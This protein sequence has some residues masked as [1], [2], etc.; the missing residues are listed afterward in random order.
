MT[1]ETRPAAADDPALVRAVAGGSEAALAEL[2]DRHVGAIFG[3]VVR[4]TGDRGV[5]EEVVQETFLALWDRA[6]LYDAA[7]GSLATWL[8]AIARN[9]AIDRLRAAG[10]RPR[11]VSIEADGDDDTRDGALERVAARGAIIGGAG[12]EPDPEDAAVRSELG[13]R[14]RDALGTM[15]ELERDTIVLAYRDGL[16]QSEIA[17]RLGWPIGTVKTRTRRALARLRQ[18]LGP[19]FAP[20]AGPDAAPPYGHGAASAAPPGYGH[21][22]VPDAL[23]DHAPGDSPDRVLGGIDGPR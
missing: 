15:P 20:D 3:L 11:L 5:A 8:R 7:V 4:L 6:E 13:A 19:A 23:P 22:A 2:Y 18:S 9:R 10:R 21:T 17:E 12:A 14:L 1:S 16:T